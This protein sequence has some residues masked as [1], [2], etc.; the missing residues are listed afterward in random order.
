LRHAL[1][2][3]PEVLD[4]PLRLSTPKSVTWNPDGSQRVILHSVRHAQS[5]SLTRNRKQ[6]FQ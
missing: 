3:D 1:E 6:L 2:R 4:A 5:V